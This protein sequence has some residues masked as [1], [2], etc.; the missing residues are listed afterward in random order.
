MERWSRSD[1][2]LP[3]LGGLIVALGYVLPLLPANF[4]GFFPLLLW[5]DARDDAGRWSRAKAGFVFGVLAYGVTLH[6]FWAL[7][8]F[9]WLAF[10]LYAGFTVLGA[11]R[12]AL[13]AMLLGW[14]RR[15]TGIS[16]GILLPATWLP[17]E[18]LQTFGDLRMTGDHMA[19]S[20]SRYP[21][22]VQFADLIGP[23]GVGAFVL[24]VNG[25]LFEALLHRGRPAGKRAAIALA[26]LLA[27]TLGY[28][29]WA[30]TRPAPRGETLRVALVQ[31]DIPL[32]VK[33]GEDT[34]AEQWAKLADLTKQAARAVERP[35]LIVWPES[36]RPR[37]LYHWL[38]VPETYGMGDVAGLA[39]RTGIPLLVGVEYYQ[40]RAEDDFDMYNAAMLVHRNGRLD[41][42]WT[43]KIYLVPFV[44]ATP[45]RGL[46]G[47]LVEGRGGEWNWLAG[48]FRPG[49]RETLF[50]V[51]G[52]RLG[53]LVCYEQLFAELARDLRNAGAQF[54][55]V[56]TNDAWFGRTWFQAYQANA[57]R[58]RAIE[59]R[60][61]FVRAA[62]TGI[63]GF[64]D[65]YG[66]YHRRT[67][68]F[69]TAVEIH[70]V[71]LSDERTVYNRTGDVVIWPVWLALIYAAVAAVR[72]GRRG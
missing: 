58:L 11:A 20:V 63:S 34:D 51:G 6:F 60:S 48:G 8:R 9:S 10:V 4:V 41:P 17:F 66:R 57:L 56:I 28:D 15:R 42:T 7:S 39:M 72:G 27:L 45:F 36:A 13:F 64:V 62:N 31:P 1:W 47:P 30:W 65:R 32:L 46:L 3:A 21:F 37:P 16:W 54:Q 61:A 24:A 69:A 19:L 29:A 25:L 38:N 2:K 59:N 26:V 40:V 35:D 22:L 55:V 67:P 33:R 53:V 44:E 23:Y 49:P 50:D 14:L 18:W 5:M 52:A 70:E 68:L 71:A 12:I 43:A